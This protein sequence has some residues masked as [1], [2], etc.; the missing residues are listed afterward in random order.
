ME[1][2]EF[3]SNA[4]ALCWGQLGIIFKMAALQSLEKM[5]AEVCS[6]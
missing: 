3:S 5:F 6:Q 2:Q 1:R 4:N